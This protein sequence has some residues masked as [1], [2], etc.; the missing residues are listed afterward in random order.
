MAE[1]K[2]TTQELANLF[3]ERHNI[4][5]SEADAFIREFFLLIEDMLETEKSVK[6]KGLGTFKL[7]LVKSRESINVNTGQRFEIQEHHKVSFTPDASLRDLI[8]KPFG[9]FETIILND[10]ISFG[11]DEIEVEVKEENVVEEKN[12]NTPPVHAEETPLNETETEKPSPMS[13]DDE[14]DDAENEE[15]EAVEEV[16][17][18]EEEKEVVEEEVVEVALEEE[19]EINNGQSLEKD[20]K[21]ETIIEL[22]TVVPGMPPLP[23]T[24]NEPAEPVAPPFALQ[25]DSQ[26]DAPREATETT[27]PAVDEPQAPPS[28]EPVETEITEDSENE[29]N[30]SI[31]DTE[32]EQ[33]EQTA[34]DNRTD[35]EPVQKRSLEEIIAREL[36]ETHRLFNKTLRG[37]GVGAKPDSTVSKRAFMAGS[38]IAAI[39]ICGVAVLFTYFP[40]FMD[41]LFGYNDR[42]VA[43]ETIQP[44]VVPGPELPDSLLLEFEARKMMRDSKSAL[45]ESTDTEDK[46]IAEILAKMDKEAKAA[47]A[48][49]D[50]A[51]ATSKD[52]MATAKDSVATPKQTAPETKPQPEV[53]KPKEQSIPQTAQKPADKPVEKK[54][55]DQKPIE[56]KPVAQKPVEQKPVVA[57]STKEAEKPSA[58]APVASGTIVADDT[59]VRTDSVSYNIVG[60]RTT[61]TILQGETL[62]R[63]SLRFYGTKDLWPY[64]V[65][66]NP[67]QIP[68]P[69]IVPAGITIKIPE[70]EKK[71][72]K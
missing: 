3:A 62:T 57:Q 18:E 50:S 4:D 37:E 44:V 47:V 34:Q 22:E 17:V 21:E 28:A 11:D 25:P 26:E 55:A 36:H 53:E 10:N 8:N 20:A 16:V 35:E 13:E 58:A 54:P 46:E 19:E 15:N 49:K 5:Q 12:A 71:K 40:S 2:I 6:I 64:L 38:I 30:E 65:K 39:L 41:N 24:N 48:L 45:G 7:V 23:S 14:E 9:H 52:S 72:K 63:V 51:A 61:H 66:H 42:S 68:D 31:E 60:T 67:E 43:E 69:Q 27:P 29:D 33:T 70:L 32:A 59:P 56:Q 1:D